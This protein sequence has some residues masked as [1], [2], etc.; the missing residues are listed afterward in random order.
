MSDPF[1]TLTNNSNFKAVKI[2]G[3]DIYLNI[4]EKADL[5]GINSNGVWIKFI[6]EKKDPLTGTIV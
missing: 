2:D 1:E 4:Y 5:Y 6:S 3:R